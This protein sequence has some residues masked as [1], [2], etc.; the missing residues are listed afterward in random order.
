MGITVDSNFIIDVLR[1]D[2]AAVAKAR[3]LDT[4]RESK[5]LST[6]V[7]YEISAGLLFTRSRSEAAAFHGF[8]S[9][10]AILPFDE[11]SA[12]R[13]AEIRAELMR[14]GRPKGHVDVMI[15]GTAS[16]GGHTLVSR[17]RDFR[18]IAKTVGLNIEGY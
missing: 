11:A 5:F 6:P 13:A 14:L 8:A 3:D 2:A 16:V 9:R 12:M 18:D 4:R 10:F 15:A 17:D 1:S 7:L